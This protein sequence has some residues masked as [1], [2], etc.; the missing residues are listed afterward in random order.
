M[1]SQLTGPY[2]EPLP[3][4]PRS[5]AEMIVSAV[6]A[7]PDASLIEIGNDGTLARTQFAELLPR[8]CAMNESLK[9]R[10]ISVERRLVLCFD[11]LDEFLSAAWAGVFGGYWCVP[12]YLS[13]VA[14]ANPVFAT[15]LRHLADCFPDALFV[16]PERTEGLLRERLPELCA[17]DILRIEDA[18]AGAAVADR[19]PALAAARGGGF[20][21]GTSGTSGTAKFARVPSRILLNRHLIAP[22]HRAGGVRLS[23]FPFDGVTG[24]AAIVPE[25]GAYIHVDPSWLTARPDSFLQLVE[26]HKVT[27]LVVTSSMADRLLSVMP[28]GGSTPD[29]SSLKHVVIGAELI[30]PET[31]RRFVDALEA[32]GA[33]SISMSVGYGMTEAGTICRAVFPS[34]ERLLAHLGDGTLPVSVGGCTRFCNLRITNDND[35]ILPEGM[36]GNIQISSDVRLFEGYETPDGLDR[37][38][39]T[40]DGWFRTGDRGFVDAGELRIE[41]RGQHEIMIRGNSYSL[42]RIEAELRTEPELRGLVVAAVAL[43][44]TGRAMDELAVFLLPPSEELDISARFVNSARKA[45]V[46]ACGSAPAHIVL[47]R[48]D[49]IVRTGNGKLV[50]RALAEALQS[51]ALKSVTTGA[52]GE[53]CAEGGADSADWIEAVWREKLEVSDPL[54]AEESFFDLGGDSM[55]CAEL[56]SIVERKSG[57][58]LS[59]NQFFAEPTLAKMNALVVE[60]L[61]LPAQAQNDAQPGAEND[62]LIRKLELFQGSWRGRRLFAGS[63]L[64][65]ENTSGNKPPLFW[66]FQQEKEFSQ[67]AKALG[68][69]QPLY[70]LRSLAG[71][72]P[73]RD[74]NSSVLE[75]VCNRYLWE[76]L[77]VAD[78]GPMV[79]GGN[80]QAGIIA[81]ALARRLRQ[82]GR[83]P[84]TLVLME[85]CYSY[86]PYE[87]PVLLIYGRQSRTSLIYESEEGAGPNWRADFPAHEVTGIEGAHGQFFRDDRVPGLSNALAPVLGMLGQSSGL[88]SIGLRVRRA[89]ANR[90]A[91]GTPEFP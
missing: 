18:L 69:A 70:G 55:S 87:D 47:V 13:P 28:A 76:I 11:R 45:C 66:V 64:V 59:L 40:A 62:D 46:K 90:L 61:D 41:G 15:R 6:R 14:A 25:T 63:L 75:E 27:S 71:I 82:I 65:G 16:V 21:I 84:R 19:E 5:L 91:S 23:Y 44:Q 26:E 17:E 2:D 43:K 50:R 72:L 73:V 89:L 58:T 86:G 88:R 80:C 20:L 57:V 78:E 74:Y 34:A 60:G 29:L 52:E 79:V 77:S 10:N 54:P 85:W 39:F 42:E 24:L 51:G 12:L 33:R 8:A 35:Q 30:M 56:I 36:S 67:L 48:E 7:H 53:T 31:A 32:R 37:T 38:C 1:M 49:Q 81:L 83:A 4:T 3:D 9:S 68:P 22:A